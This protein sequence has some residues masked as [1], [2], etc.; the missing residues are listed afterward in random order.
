[1]KKVRTSDGLR[2]AYQKLCVA[3]SDAPLTLPQTAVLGCLFHKGPMNQ[4]KMV[5]ASG[6]DRSTLAEML[7]RLA[8]MGA[9]VAMQMEADKRAN[10]VSITTRGR[11]LFIKAEGALYEAEAGI[12]R[13]VPAPDRAAFQRALTALAE[14][15]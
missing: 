5:A 6:I 14:A 15:T 2:R 4:T 10:M 11:A 1:M 8:T 7:R 3:F 13:L 9:V 12:M